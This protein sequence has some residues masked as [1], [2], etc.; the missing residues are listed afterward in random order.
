MTWR[1][2]DSDDRF[3]LYRKGWNPD[4]ETLLKSLRTTGWSTAASNYFKAIGEVDWE[5]VVLA[6]DE[7]GRLAVVASAGEEDGFL[8]TLA[9]FD[10][11]LFD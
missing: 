1:E 4:E 8:A 10:A 3:V 6:E 9:V 11:E 2:L 5:F 7:D